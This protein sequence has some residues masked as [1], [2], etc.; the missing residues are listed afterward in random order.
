MNI[1][2]SEQMILRFVVFAASDEEAEDEDE[3]SSR[4]RSCWRSLPLFVLDS[5]EAFDDQNS[6]SVW[7]GDQR[8]CLLSTSATYS[9][10]V[11]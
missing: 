4:E 10:Q 1:V 2:R 3:V 11:L 7:I 9:S 8:R 6:S 5:L